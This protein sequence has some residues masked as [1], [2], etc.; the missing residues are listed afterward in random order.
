MGV[1]GEQ[2]A[3]VFLEQLHSW[4]AHCPP[5]PFCSPFL[6][7]PLS[8]SCLHLPAPLRTLS[9]VIILSCMADT[10]ATAAQQQV[11]RLLNRQAKRQARATGV[12]QPVVPP[13]L[14]PVPS[15][16]PGLPGARQLPQIGACG[17]AA[18]ANQDEAADEAAGEQQQA[19]DGSAAAGAMLPPPPPPPQQQQVQQQAQQQAEG[20][21]DWEDAWAGQAD[22]EEWEEVPAGSPSAPRTT[23]DGEQ[24]TG[25]T[26]GLTIVLNRDGSEAAEGSQ[27]GKAGVSGSSAR[28]RG[29]T[30]ADR[31][32]AQ[33]VHRSHLLCLLARAQALDAAASDPLLQAQLL[34]LVPQGPAAKLHEGAAG[35][36]TATAVGAGGCSL[37][38]L[39]QQVQ[40]F[41]TTFKLLPPTASSSSSQ[42]TPDPVLAAL[43]APS[44][45]Q[46]WLQQLGEALEQRAGAA[47]QLI[48]LFAALLRGQGALVRTVRV[49]EPS[50]LRPTGKQGDGKAGLQGRALGTREWGILG[51]R[52][53]VAPRRLQGCSCRWF[54][55]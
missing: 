10:L 19:A 17:A 42:G 21:Q 25:G 46:A 39:H 49:L 4:R 41:K 3:A 12:Q 5:C 51:I 30:K 20:S 31:E 50:S 37:A 33:L 45:P 13:R 40:W 8:S 43:L 22:D 47:E 36:S 35:G 9:A 24:E 48:G 34:S 14:G 2:E 7:H 53:C 38:G 23:E 44:G 18:V 27:G 52:N 55:A 32:R 28:R 16:V 6:Q 1:V 26:E 15:L 29:V 54:A 11:E